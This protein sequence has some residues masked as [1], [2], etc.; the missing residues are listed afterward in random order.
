MC[1][2]APSIEPVMMDLQL[3]KV[4]CTEQNHQTKLLQDL[5]RQEKNTSTID[6]VPDTILRI[7]KQVET[8]KE[9]IQVKIYQNNSLRASFWTETIT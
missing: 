1:P 4:V 7:Q 8:A 9:V 5:L 2:L 3:K 6:M